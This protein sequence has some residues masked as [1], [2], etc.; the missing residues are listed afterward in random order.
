MNEWQHLN[1]VLLLISECTAANYVGGIA[2]HRINE[3][4]SIGALTTHFHLPGYGPHNRQF[5]SHSHAI[6]FSPDNSFALMCDLGA[7][8]IWRLSFESEHG[9]MALVEGG[10]TSTSDDRTN[11]SHSR[12]PRSIVI[13]PSNLYVFV[14]NE[15]YDSVSS[16]RLNDG[17]GRPLELL[18]EVNTVPVGF[19]PLSPNARPEFAGNNNGKW[20]SSVVVTPQWEVCLCCQPHCGSHCHSHSHA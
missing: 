13:H 19:G 17:N 18:N 10:H 1:H 7:D 12:G 2:V 8:M 14:S 3:D 20:T 15:L 4:G 16:Y 11:P 5:T 6:V 9:R